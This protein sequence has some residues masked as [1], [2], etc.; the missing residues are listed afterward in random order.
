MAYIHKGTSL[1]YDM[2]PIEDIFVVLKQ[3]PT[4]NPKREQP[5]ARVTTL[6]IQVM[7]EVIN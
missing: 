2:L 7:K 4:N 5:T 6:N 1:W 3:N